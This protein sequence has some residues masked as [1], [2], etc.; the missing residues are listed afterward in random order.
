MTLVLHTSSIVQEN[1]WGRANHRP[2]DLSPHSLGKEGFSS[3]KQII[4]S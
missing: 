2:I 1:S 4:K 3:Q